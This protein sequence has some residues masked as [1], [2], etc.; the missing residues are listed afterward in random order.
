MKYVLSIVPHTHWDREWYQTFQGFRHRLVKLVDHLLHVLDTDPKFKVFNL[1][2]QTVVLEDYLEIRPENRA[3][4]KRYIQH[5]R[6]MV[7]PWY[8]LPDEFLV[9]GESFA[10]NLIFGFRVARQF[11]RPMMAGYLPDQF[12]H[13]AA[14][15]KIVKGAGMDSAII[16]RGVGPDVKHTEFAWRGDDGTTITGFYMPHGY[17]NAMYLPLE[18]EKLAGKLDGEARSLIPMARTN[19]LL[20]MNGIDH[21]EPQEGLPAALERVKGRLKQSYEIVSL[22]KH[23]REVRK[24]ASLGKLKVHRGEFRRQDRA[25]LLPGVLSTRVNLKQRSDQLEVDLPAKAEPLCSLASLE[26]AAYPESYLNLAWRELL[27]NHPHDSICGCSIDEVHREMETRFQTSEDIVRDVIGDATGFL[28]DRIR[29]PVSEPRIVVF[30]PGGGRRT[31]FVRARAGDGKAVDFVARDIPAY[32]Y[33]TYRLSEVA[34]REGPAVTASP[35]A[36]ENQHFKVTLNGNGTVNILDKAAGKTFRNCGAI[37]DSGDVGD[38]Y[39]YSPAPEN[40]V[41]RTPASAKWRVLECTGGRGEVEAE[42]KFRWPESVTPDRRR[43]SAKR[44]IGTVRHRIALTAGVPRVE[45]ATTI[46]NTAKDHRVRVAF[47]LPFRIGRARAFNHFGTVERG[48]KPIAV[49][50]GAPERHIGTY[51]NLGYVQAGAGSYSMTLGNIG[52]REYEILNSN[53][54]ALTLLRCVGWLSR[55]DFAYRPGN[56]G[57]EMPAPE[58]QMIGTWTLKYAF[59]AGNGFQPVEQA[60]LFRTGVIAR[61]APAGRGGPL[62]PEMS[63]LKIGPGEVSLAAV[64]RAEDRKGIVVRVFSLAEREVEAAVEF[65]RGFRKAAAVNLVEAPDRS[66]KVRIEGRK[67]RFRIRPNQVVSLRMVPRGRT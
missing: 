39:N 28:M 9:S 54:I 42:L 62:P 44:V 47:P 38:E 34:G 11:G 20:I 48:T 21:Q 6:I 7:G 43:R 55:G 63:M 25:H 26:G 16:W 17:G 19:R 40:V 57:P 30:N 65:Y 52:L 23:V 4:L 8:I 15:P 3:K 2:G 13:T 37:E 35:K 22:E 5:G 29:G 1:D 53:T 10:R 32:G 49:P 18:E 58:A 41:I 59:S 56:A 66:V 33:R 64:K 27:R 31:E 45:F 51:P 36:V 46:E 24:Q 14:I 60:N 50:K 12:G 67:I 61:Y